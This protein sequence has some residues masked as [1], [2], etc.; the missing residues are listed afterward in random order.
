MARAIA[1]RIYQKASIVYD[2]QCFDYPCSVMGVRHLSRIY[3]DRDIQSIVEKVKAK[4]PWVVYVN[5]TYFLFPKIAVD[6]TLKSIRSTRYN[7][8][9]IV[10]INHKH[11]DPASYSGEVIVW[12]FE[13][14]ESK[15]GWYGHL[16]ASH[17]NRDLEIAKLQALHTI[18]KD[19][20]VRVI[21][22]LKCTSV[23]TGFTSA[24]TLLFRTRGDME[25]ELL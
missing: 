10:A 15:D 25:I 18:Q 9:R 6:Y 7:T 21:A 2:E 24:T 12:Q 13:A 19:I 5:D 23:C 4:Y 8:D 22:Y 3:V 1:H 20:R 11:P 16:L 17:M 14:E